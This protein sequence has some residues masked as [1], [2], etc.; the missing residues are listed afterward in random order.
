MSNLNKMIK[1]KDNEYD[2]SSIAELLLNN[3]ILKIAEESFYITEI[4]FY[5]YSNNHSNCSIHKSEYQLF[6]NTWYVHTKGRGGLDITFGN[7]DKKEFGGILIRGIK[8]VTTNQYIDGPTNVLKHILKILD[9]E[10][11]ELQPLL[12]GINTSII[13]IIKNDNKDNFLFQGPRIGLVQ[14]HNEYLVSPYRYII[15]ATTNHKFKEKSNVYCYSMK[16]N[17]NQK[18]CIEDE[19]SYK[20]DTAKYIASLDKKNSRNKMIINFLES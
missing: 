11:K 10:R 14:E 2:F 18:S 16:L 3:S 9:L 5:F 6:S 12:L 17:E 20:L 13:K 8:S 7:K 4:E 1:I 19:F 15:D